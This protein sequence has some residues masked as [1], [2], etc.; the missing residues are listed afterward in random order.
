MHVFFE[1][2][3][4]EYCLEVQLKANKCYVLCALFSFSSIFGIIGAL[5]WHNRLL[6]GHSW[7]R[8]GKE[9]AKEFSKQQD[10]GSTSCKYGN[11]TK[12]DESRV[13]YTNE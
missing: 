11:K 7:L 9:C 13:Y 6:S 3:Y 5:A 1:Y 4:G 8:D 12:A 10:I 2:V